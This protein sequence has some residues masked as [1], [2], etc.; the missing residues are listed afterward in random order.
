MPPSLIYQG[1]DN[2]PQ[3]I[4]ECDAVVEVIDFDFKVAKDTGTDFIA[5]KLREIKSGVLLYDNLVFSAN[6]EWRVETFLKA[7]GFT[8][9][10]GQRVDFTKEFCQKHVVRARAWAHLIVDEYKGKKRNEVSTW[11]TDKPIPEKGKPETAKAA[12]PPK[13]DFDDVAATFPKEKPSAGVD[14]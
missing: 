9:Q 5:L 1:R 7:I 6:S 8:P 2:L 11:I 4:D 13:S 14:W 3:Y 10:L 12:T